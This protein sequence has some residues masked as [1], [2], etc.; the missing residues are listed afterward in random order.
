MKALFLT[1]RKE[2]NIM[3]VVALLFF[4]IFIAFLFIAPAGHTW[5]MSF[6]EWIKAQFIAIF[7]SIQELL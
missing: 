7:S 6:I 1:A 5:S 2:M 4:V 3:H